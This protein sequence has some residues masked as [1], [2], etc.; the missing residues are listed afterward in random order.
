V[1]VHAAPTPK[2]HIVN[3]VTFDPWPFAVESIEMSPDTLYL[4]DG[5][6]HSEG[7]WELN[8]SENVLTTLSD[9]RMVLSDTADARYVA[10]C[11]ELL[12]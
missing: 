7:G 3:Q 11:L 1:K 6:W 5:V 10:D 2:L 4:W 12:P 8:S 9:G